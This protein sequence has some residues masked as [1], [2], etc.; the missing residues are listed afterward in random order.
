MEDILAF[1]SEVAY[2]L[3]TFFDIKT[4]IHAS[5]VC[6]G[7]KEVASSQ[8]LWKEI[9]LKYWKDT[10][11]SDNS[12]FIDWKSQVIERMTKIDVIFFD[13]CRFPSPPTKLRMTLDFRDNIYTWKTKFSEQ[14]GYRLGSFEFKMSNLSQQI[15]LNDQTYLKNVVFPIPKLIIINVMRSAANSFDYMFPLKSDTFYGAK[16]RPILPTFDSF[17]LPEF[18]PTAAEIEYVQGVLVVDSSQVFINLLFANS[19]HLLCCL[20]TKVWMLCLALCFKQTDY[21]YT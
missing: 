15:V 1:P 12:G 20:N 14:V 16:N 5:M 7:W 9:F 2:Q 3:F 19:R 13:C 6:K 17:T 11:L 10:R 18:V 4:I 21:I 8:Q